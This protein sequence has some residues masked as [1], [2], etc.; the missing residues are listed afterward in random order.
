M[1]WLGRKGD[2]GL[3]DTHRVSPLPGPPEPQ[4]T[5]RSPVREFIESW[6]RWRQASEDVRG[7]YET[8]QQCKTE[9]GLAFAGYRAALDREDHA[10]RVYSMCADRVR[11]AGGGR[12]V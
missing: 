6:V 12:H 8:W 5:C 4:Q 7:A 10:A 9:R 1:G 3:P 2:A 11:E